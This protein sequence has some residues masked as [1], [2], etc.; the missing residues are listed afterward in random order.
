MSRAKKAIIPV[1]VD[2]MG[3]PTD[4]LDEST[5]RYKCPVKVGDR[6]YRKSAAFNN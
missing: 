5:L 6:F 3:I 1:H 2:E 4:A